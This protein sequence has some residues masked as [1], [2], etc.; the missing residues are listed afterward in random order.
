MVMSDGVMIGNKLRND[1]EDDG[2]D[3]DDLSKIIIGN[4]L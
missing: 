2:D 4:V 3:N 1:D